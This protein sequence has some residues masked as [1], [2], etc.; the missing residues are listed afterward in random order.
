MFLLIIKIMNWVEMGNL[1]QYRIE[2]WFGWAIA[3]LF[4][5]K[6]NV[7]DNPSTGGHKKYVSTAFFFFHTQVLFN[8]PYFSCT[9]ISFHLILPASSYTLNQFFTEKNM[10]WEN[11]VQK[12][13]K[14]LFFS[15]R[16]SFLSFFY[17][18]YLFSFFLEENFLLFLM[19]M[20]KKI[21]E[22]PLN[23]KTHDTQHFRLKKN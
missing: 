16:F 15:E 11:S 13:S 22:N 8:F 6:S 10:R 9:N 7:A 3:K 2:L 19:W 18:K 1:Q 14:N 5:I 20:M 23:T 12:R 21:W 17:S 4:L